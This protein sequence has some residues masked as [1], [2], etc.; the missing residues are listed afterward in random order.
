MKRADETIELP[1]SLT[2]NEAYQAAGRYVLDHCDVLIAIWDGR[3]EQ[4]QGGTASI[5]A[6]A[7]QRGMPIA[8]VHTGSSRPGIQEATSPGEE[9]GALTFERFPTGE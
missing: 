6:Q 2:R 4:H 8:W 3:K 1:L 5:V 7:R 9:Q